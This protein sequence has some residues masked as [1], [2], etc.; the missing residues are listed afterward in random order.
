MLQA[1]RRA[2]DIDDN[3]VQLKQP[4][5]EVVTPSDWMM[6]TKVIEIMPSERSFS[7]VSLSRVGPFTQKNQCF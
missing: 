1:K 6:K 7:V 3:L 2:L 5:C 4:P